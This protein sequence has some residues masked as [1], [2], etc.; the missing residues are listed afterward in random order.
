M[1]VQIRRSL[2]PSFSKVKVVRFLFLLLLIGLP[3]IEISLFIKVGGWI[4]ILP[5]ILLVFAMS[6]LGTALLRRQGLQSFTRAQSAMQRGEVPVGDMLDGFFLAAA[7]I[8]FILPGFFSDILGFALLLPPVRKALGAYLRSRFNV[9]TE[10]STFYAGPGGP[11]S[12]GPIIEGE[13]EEV[14]E[15]INPQHRL[16]P[17][18]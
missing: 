4:G 9:Q 11:R 3:V 6:V 17:K 12:G 5:T 16:P 18:S 13:A 15:E 7:A 2:L 10:Q 14:R 1:R 8:L